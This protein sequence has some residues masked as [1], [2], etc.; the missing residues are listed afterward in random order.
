M[1][2]GADAIKQP[3]PRAA[4]AAQRA[5]EVGQ[6]PNQSRTWAPR[7]RYRPNQSRTSPAWVSG[8]KTG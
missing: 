4:P 5:P 6:R 7:P 1:E 3:Q 2:A 8:G